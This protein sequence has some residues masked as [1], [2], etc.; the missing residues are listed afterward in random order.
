M[1]SIRKYRRRTI[2]DKSEFNKISHV[3]QVREQRLKETIDEKCDKIAEELN[4]NTKGK[5]GKREVK[6]IIEVLGFD[7]NAYQKSE[8]EST[9]ER[10]HFFNLKSLKNWVAKNRHFILCRVVNSEDSKS[11][12]NNKEEFPNKKYFKMNRTIGNPLPSIKR[13][14]RTLSQY[15]VPKVVDN[16]ILKSYVDCLKQNEEN[17]RRYKEQLEDA[18]DAYKLRNRE[19]GIEYEK[20]V[21]ERL[22]KSLRDHQESYIKNMELLSFMKQNCQQMTKIRNKTIDNKEIGNS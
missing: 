17:K 3:A 20:K 22:N 21:M 12:K 2:D 8:L 16:V 7:L 14:R 19:K 1:K 6:H 18:L 9:V 10:A 15:Q 5:L 11:Y 4:I 13:N